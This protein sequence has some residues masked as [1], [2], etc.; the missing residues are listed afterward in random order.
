M[1]KQLAIALLLLISNLTTAASQQ[2]WPTEIAGSDCVASKLFA[3][4]S[5]FARE[6]DRKYC[7]LHNS[8]QAQ[9][10][11]TCLDNTA[12]DQE[13]SFFSN[14]CSSDTYYLGINGKQYE[15]KRKP[16]GKID[17]DMHI[18]SFVGKDVAMTVRFVK[19]ITRELIDGDTPSGSAA[20]AVELKIGKRVERS[21][22]TLF[23]GP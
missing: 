20:V 15:L 4:K 21:K 6:E 12:G 10:L 23:Y 2:L 8:G 17:I 5:D 1:R 22:A 16:S 7:E 14:R 9:A 11:Q 19:H 18:G 13:V 3:K